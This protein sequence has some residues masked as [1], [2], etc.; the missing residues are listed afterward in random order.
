MSTI[1]FFD[2]LATNQATRDLAHRLA[3]AWAAR[4]VSYIGVRRQ[5]AA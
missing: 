2:Y 4:E 5:P 3:D 1:D